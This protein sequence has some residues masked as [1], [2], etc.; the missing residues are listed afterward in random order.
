MKSQSSVRTT[1]KPSKGM[2]ATMRTKSK[3]TVKAK[4]KGRT[5]STVTKK[6]LSASPIKVVK[7]AKREGILYAHIKEENFAW[8]KAQAKTSDVSISDYT[9]Q[10][11]DHVRKAKA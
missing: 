3:R 11:I 4:T 7:A 9:D 1:R 5:M 6:P 8:I 2:L 10:L